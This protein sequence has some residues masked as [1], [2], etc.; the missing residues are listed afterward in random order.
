MLYGLY[1]SAQG[2]DAQSTRLDLIANN[3]ANAGTNAFK[4][5]LA[6][7]AARD[8]HDVRTGQPGNAPNNL[9]ESTGGTDLLD[10]VTD[11]SDAAHIQTGGTFDVAISGPGFLQVSDGERQFL[12][13][14]G[15]LTKN[16]NGELVTKDTGLNVLSASGSPIII[17][18]EAV[19]VNFASDGTMNL[20][21]EAGRI[22]VGGRLAIVAPESL[23]QMSK[24]GDSLYIAEGEVAPTNDL[25]RVH[26]GFVEASGT[27]S[28][29]EML[30]LIDAS[31]AFETNVSMI[32]FQDEALGR[33]LQAVPR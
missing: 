20:I 4:R 29:G 11:F 19:D 7:F 23:D 25:A 5:D 10:V 16:L 27:Q 18:P 30:N 21:D 12:T 13:R 1:L 8:P 9:D 33:L 17:P 6:I 28:V 22:A 32:K 24:F 26:Q 31:R 15:A 2:A 3:L 14:N